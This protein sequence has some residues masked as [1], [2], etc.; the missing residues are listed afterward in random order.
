M[1]SDSVIPFNRPSL[2]GAELD[3]MLAAVTTG[4][5]AANGPF[6]ARVCEN[7]RAA[8]GAADVLLTTSCTDALELAALMLDLGPNDDVIVPSF[9]FVSTALAFTRTGARIRFVDIEPETLGIDPSCVAATLDERVRAV[10]AVHYAGIGCDVNG[11]RA[12]IADTPAVLVEDNAHGLF[13]TYQ[14]RP[15]A[16]FG[17][18]ATL[19]FHETKNFICGEGGALVLNDTADIDRAHVL[20]DKG[21]N[22]RSFLRGDV[23]QY[24]W[25]DTGSSFGLSDL[26]AAFLLAQ[27]EAKDVVL[28]KRQLIFDTYLS[29]LEPYEDELD[30]RCIRVPNGCE[31]A[32]HMF[33]VLLP[34]RHI[35][36]LVLE[37]LTRA[38]VHAVF[39]Y[40]PLH[41][42]P[43]AARFSDGTAECP[44]TDDISARL[45]RLPFYNALT[46]T[47]VERVVDQFV[48]AVHAATDTV[49]V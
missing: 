29:L 40:V 44:V 24:T 38:G 25:V 15:L 18:F 20:L 33:Y 5:I 26:L 30:I 12:A 1:P 10:V 23:D 19:S 39:H 42:S 34:S 21:T 11:L 7:L 4:Y 43:A 6:S 48:Q 13:G 46:V 47:D 17:R 14:G 2:E 45:V 27:L 37:L 36:D 32:Y 9:S 16:S 31:P 49:D 22:R 8:L 41:S 28:A 35:R 3:N